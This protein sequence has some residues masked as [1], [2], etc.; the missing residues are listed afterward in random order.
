LIG[1]RPVRIGTRGSRLAM[2]QAHAVSS[3]LESAG[4]GVEI[5][6]VKTSG[7]RA[8]D[9]PAAPLDAHKRQFVKELEDALLAGTVDV[10][11]HSAKDMPVDL[12]QGLTVAACLPREDP[13]DAL[14]LAKTAGALEW[15]D[16]QARL[17]PGT[18]I[19]TSSVRRTSQLGPQLP[20]VRF[21]PIRGNVD[22]RIA[23]LDG[24]AADA[25]VLACAGLRRLGFAHRITAV[26]P[27]DRCVPAP[28]Q[29]I[30]ATEIRADDD[31][32]R[33][34]LDRIHD[35]AAGRA[36]AAE[37]ALVVRLGGGCQLPLGGIAVEHGE[38]LEMHALV[39]SLDG[40][41]FVR[42]SLAGPVSEPAELGR[43]LA[44]ALADSGAQAIL[45]E[46]R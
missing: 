43:R 32:T 18:V 7:D 4:V 38:M 25:L 14:L 34:A 33:R 20:G 27:I 19:G 26:L 21:A 46:L 40:S 37:R 29:G 24:G 36:L 9:G 12:P 2:W 3:R 6:V 41:R 15:V 35:D 31:G 23:K 5:V 8:Q 30:V 16:V 22:T 28:G 1:S 13:L 10:A 44:D 45:D 11:V 39:A 17:K 42:R